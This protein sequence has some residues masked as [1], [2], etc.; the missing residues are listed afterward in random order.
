MGKRTLLDL[1]M[2]V[3]VVNK[4][5]SPAG[6]LD[7]IHGVTVGGGTTTGRKGSG[8]ERRDFVQRIATLTVGVTGVTGLDVDRLTATALEP[9]HTSVGVAEL[10]A[11]VT[12]PAA[13]MKRENLVTVCELRY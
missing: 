1:R 11:R 4:L 8:V 12:T 10:R 9:L 6:K 13:Y 3:R 7:F 2:V 5:V